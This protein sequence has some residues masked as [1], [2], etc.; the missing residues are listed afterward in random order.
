MVSQTR[1]PHRLYFNYCYY[2][3]I[4]FPLFGDCIES[5]DPAWTGSLLRVLIG[6]PNIAISG[7]LRKCARYST[8]YVLFIFYMLYPILRQNVPNKMSPTKYTRHNIP[9][10]NIP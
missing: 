7:F 4:N 10:Q 3:L 8:L 5:I 9:E 2:G 6:H 1:M